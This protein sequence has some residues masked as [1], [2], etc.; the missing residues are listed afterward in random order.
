MKRTQ[1]IILLIGFVF[2]GVAAQAQFRSIPGAVTDSFKVHYPAASDVKWSDKVTLFQASFTNNGD[3]YLA[4]FKSKG[5]WLSSQKD[6]AEDKLP[7]VVKD[8]LAKSKYA[9]YKIENVKQIF[10]P[11][12]VTQYG[13]S[14]SNGSITKKNLLFNSEGQLLKDNTTL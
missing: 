8:G 2:F 13:L 7:S 10:L 14:V 1:S 6:I 5:E 12:N 3:A 11:N 4:K 9:S